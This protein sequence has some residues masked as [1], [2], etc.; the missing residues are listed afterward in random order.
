MKI[1]I[2]D[3]K[4][5]NL[6]SVKKAFSKL[7]FQSTISNNKVDIENA[8][9]LV[10]PGVGHFSNTM[11]N[12]KKLNILQVLNEQVLEKKKPILGICLGMQLLSEY[13]EEGDSEGLGWIKG[14]TK[15]FQ[16]DTS[17]FKIPHIGWNTLEICQKD[18]FL[19]NTSIND[20][21]YFVHSYHV[22]CDDYNDVAAFSEYGEK[23]TASIQKD[24]IF[25]T[26]FHPE[27]SH[28]QGLTILKSF[29][30]TNV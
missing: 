21:F 14:K 10:L 18:S 3:C 23:F 5:G 7:G 15:K 11:E 30:D 9:L 16:L 27:K 12:L 17:R 19:K 8:G 24:N 22:E 29:I 2:V 25:G 1:V 4:M 6:V 13:S 26:Q 20:Q 28:E